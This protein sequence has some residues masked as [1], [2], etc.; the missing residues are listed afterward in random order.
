MNNKG[1]A[2]TELSSYTHKSSYIFM[3]YDQ[4]KFDNVLAANFCS[5]P[6]ENKAMKMLPWNGLQDVE[7]HADLIEN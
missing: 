2:G 4:N 7:S 5:G 3:G 6:Y 1:V